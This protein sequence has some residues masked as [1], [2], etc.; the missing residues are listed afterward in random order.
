MTVMPRRAI[1]LFITLSLL[2]GPRAA[3][4]QGTQ[5]WQQNLNGTLLPFNQA[6]SVAVDTDGNVL[7]AGVTEN[8]GTRFRLHGREVRRRRDAALAADPQ[9]HLRAQ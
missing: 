9:R 5:L 7:A 2:L 6:N 3:L 1:N 4:A 8:A